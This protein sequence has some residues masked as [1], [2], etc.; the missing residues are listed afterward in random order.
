[1]QRLKFKKIH[2]YFILKTIIHQK[3]NFFAIVSRLLCRRN[4]LKRKCAAVDTDAATKR[5]RVTL[6]K[7]MAKKY[8]KNKI[9][10]VNVYTYFNCFYEENKL[11]FPWLKKDTLRWHIR[12]INKKE[13]TND[14]KINTTTT[15]ITT[16]KGHAPNF[17]ETTIIDQHQVSLTWFGYDIIPK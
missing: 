3:R 1:M 8:K 11:I 2:H 15:S 10:K 7:Q 5:A 9:D 17:L 14:D 16:A 12:A 6:M 4:P 13:N